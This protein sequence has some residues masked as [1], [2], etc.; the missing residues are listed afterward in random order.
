MEGYLSYFFVLQVM[1]REVKL[2]V[3]DH[4]RFKSFHS[5]L[6]NFY[7]YHNSAYVLL[8]SHSSTRFVM[9]IVVLTCPPFP[10][11]K[12]VLSDSFGYLSQYL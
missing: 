5:L 4:I 8:Q 10:T 6:F 1:S 11:P 7:L 3:Q 12:N 2:V 9:K